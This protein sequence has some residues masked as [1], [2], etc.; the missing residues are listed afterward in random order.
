MS[1]TNKSRL[2]G[3]SLL[4]LGVV[5]LSIGVALLI[6][7]VFFKPLPVEAPSE[8]LEIE[9]QEEALPDEP[10]SDPQIQQE[11]QLEKSTIE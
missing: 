9:T 6:R 2:L 4:I 8:G 5:V 11:E 7:L 1:K 3:K 10:S